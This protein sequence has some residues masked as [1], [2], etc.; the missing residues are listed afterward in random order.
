MVE[1]CAG[2]EPGLQRAH[3][4]V[5]HVDVCRPRRD[6][7]AQRAARDRAPR[8]HRERNVLNVLRGEDDGGKARGEAV[9]VAVAVVLERR[10]LARVLHQQHRRRLAVLLLGVAQLLH[11]HYRLVRARG[12]HVHLAKGHV[13]HGG[14]LA[15]L[16]DERHLVHG[17][18]EYERERL[19]GDEHGAEVLPRVVGFKRR[20]R[21]L[22][23]D[24]GAV[25][26]L[27]VCVQLG[28]VGRRKHVARVG[29]ALAGRRLEVL[30]VRVDEPQLCA[31]AHA[32][33]RRHVA[34]RGREPAQRVACG[35]EGPG[36]K[37]IGQGPHVLAGLAARAVA[38]ARA[39]AHDA[40]APFYMHGVPPLRLRAPAAFARGFWRPHIK[41]PGGRLQHARKRERR[42]PRAKQRTAP[43]Y[44]GHSCLAPALRPRFQLGQHAR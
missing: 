29:A 1:L 43:G 38:H 30:G 33:V 37:M 40:P 28:D 11:A 6:C 2:A 4:E 42:F 21:V 26:R 18:R 3:H 32:Q 20:D 8:A 27:H 36:E 41:S 24:A 14:A 12:Q 17:A 19:A 39:P 15:L 44:P 23:L 5:A 9:R 22:L 13:Q 35:V 16:L 34:A 7:L 25:E 31:Q 10:F